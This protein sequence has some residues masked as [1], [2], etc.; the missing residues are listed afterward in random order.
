MELAVDGKVLRLHGI[1]VLLWSQQ[2]DRI[3]LTYSSLMFHPS[4]KFCFR[5][6]GWL[7]VQQSSDNPTSECGYQSRSRLA[8][9]MLGDATPA[10]DVETSLALSD[11]TNALSS[12]VKVKY[13]NI[14][15][16]LLMETGRADLARLLPDNRGLGSRTWSP[17]CR[18]V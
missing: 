2:A 14:Q 17:E 7:I 1:G 8:S 15:H 13:E 5:E 16:R 12:K 9:E 18:Q 4:G 11:V 3:V 6:G 10:P